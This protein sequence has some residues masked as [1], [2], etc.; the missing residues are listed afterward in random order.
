MP[1]EKPFADGDKLRA[2]LSEKTAAP[3]TRRLTLSGPPIPA[4]TPTETL[5]LLGGGNSSSLR[6]VEVTPV[7]LRGR[8]KHWLPQMSEQG[9]KHFALSAETPEGLAQ[10]EH[11]EREGKTAG[12]RWTLM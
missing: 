4:R 3:G 6:G 12:A 5:T 10:L 2:W 9:V 1:A 7:T 11:I 8:I